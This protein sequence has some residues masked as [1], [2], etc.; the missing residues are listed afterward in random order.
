MIPGAS[1]YYDG[2]TGDFI[3][4]RTHAS[5]GFRQ[6]K[7]FAI[8][9]WGADQVQNSGANNWEALGE[10]NRLRF[11]MRHSGTNKLLAEPTELLDSTDFQ[12]YWY[13]CT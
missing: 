6:L 13:A 8:N 10:A 7:N 5:T 4:E 12:D 2:S 9:Y 11:E 3:D 1:A